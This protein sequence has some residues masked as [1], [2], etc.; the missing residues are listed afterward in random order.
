MLEQGTTT[1]PEFT[2]SNAHISELLDTLHEIADVAALG[3]L[4]E[5][6]QNTAM[7]GGVADR[8]GFAETRYD[9]LLDEYEPGMTAR[10]LD[11]LFVPVRETSK[12]LLQ[13][14]EASGN[15]VEA[16]CLE[17]D[18]S[19]D[20]QIALCERLLRGMGYDF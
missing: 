15:T 1:I 11:T 19:A 18:F 8:L 7:P 5:W 14:I 17:G 2:R 20:K 12:T 16:S 13:R 9:A 10:K 3:S 4:A 6:D